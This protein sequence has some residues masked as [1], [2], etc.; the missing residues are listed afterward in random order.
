[1]YAR[2]WEPNGHCGL[3]RE[4]GHTLSHPAGF[5]L[6]A[7]FESESRNGLTFVTGKL[8]EGWRPKEVDSGGGVCC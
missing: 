2:D 8:E 4:K 1:M 6:E 3:K 7:A 5:M